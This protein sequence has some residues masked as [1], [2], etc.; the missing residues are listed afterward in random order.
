VHGN[1]SSIQETFVKFHP[2]IETM[3]GAAFFYVCAMERVPCLQLRAISNRVERRNR[4]AWKIDLALANLS[5]GVHSF[6][7]HLV[8]DYAYEN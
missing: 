3:E 1:N 6:L 2:D 8:K 5:L 4:G 7:D